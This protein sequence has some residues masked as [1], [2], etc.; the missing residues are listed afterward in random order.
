MPECLKLYLAGS[1]VDPQI[2]QI[3]KGGK[4]HISADYAERMRKRLLN[5]GYNVYGV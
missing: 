5:N 4:E 3:V 1:N 2:T